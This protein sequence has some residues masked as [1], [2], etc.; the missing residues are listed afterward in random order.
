[1]QVRWEQLLL[2]HSSCKPWLGAG[3]HQAQKLL[4]HLPC[5]MSPSPELA[6]NT[7]TLTPCLV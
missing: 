3:A 5:S 1:M 7:G 6:K 4:Q 2:L